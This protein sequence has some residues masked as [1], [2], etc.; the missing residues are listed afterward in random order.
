MSLFSTDAPISLDRFVNRRLFP[1]AAI[2]YVLVGFV[3]NTVTYL[4][5]SA[6]IPPESAVEARHGEF[7][8]GLL[9][10]V[11]VAV[12]LLVCA[13]G[14]L[15]VDRQVIRPAARIVRWAHE[16]LRHGDG[17]R[18]RTSSR[19]TEIREVADSFAILFDELEKRIRELRALVDAAR[20]DVRNRLTP[21]NSAAHA[22]LRGKKTERE[23]AKETLDGIERI[24]H[25]LDMNA[26]ITAN[27]CNIRGAATE[28]VRLY[29]IVNDCLDELEPRAYRHGVRLSAELPPPRLT[30]VAH[31]ANLEQLID[32][33]VGNAIKYT[34][35]GG[36]V[37]L[38]VRSRPD[39]IKYAPAGGKVRLAV[40]SR[41][42]AKASA[43]SQLLEIEVAD[44]GIGIPDTDK[45]HVFERR[46]R[47]E[48]AR[49]I[50]GSGYGLA[51]VDSVVA[52]YGGTCEIA[53]NSPKGTVFTVTL[54][55]PVSSPIPDPPSLIPNP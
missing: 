2:L 44:T 38:A 21:I 29:D 32:N 24:L 8:V 6:R 9:P 18:L 1:A 14:R 54:P 55:L 49:S 36:S 3:P 33:L 34:P 43:P 27:Y 4:M 45:P 42:D 19:V 37:A 51:L 5:L 22:V 26:A 39:A 48:N 20:H 46:F 50:Q 12:A 28:P 7:F 35:Q 40:R 52:L 15:V 16:R 47:A 30:V 31:A 53:D 23:A 25:V 11:V 13:Y 10:T 41:P 17:R